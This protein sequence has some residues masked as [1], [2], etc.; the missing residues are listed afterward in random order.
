MKTL[1]Q[2]FFWTLCLVLVACSPTRTAKQGHKAFENLSYFKAIEKY[3]KAIEKGAGDDFIR[4]R[5]GDSYRLTNDMAMAEKIYMQVV[6]RDHEPE[7]QLYYGQSLMSMG[8]YDKALVHLNNFKDL[9]P[10]DDRADNLASACERI[11]EMTQNHGLY[12]IVRTNVNTEHADF[13]PS[14]YQDRVIF[15]SARTR[16]RTLFSWNRTN[17]LD[18]FEA[19]YR[20]SANLGEVNDLGSNINSRFHEAITTY[21]PDGETMYFTRNNFHKGKVGFSQE[22]VIKLKIYEAKLKGKK[23][24]KTAEFPYNS[25]EYSVGHPSLTKVGDRMYFAS[26][27]PGGQGGVDIYYTDRKGD[28][29]GKPVNLGTEINTE[30]DEMFPW[31]SPEGELYYASNG[32]PGLGGLDLFLATGK[33]GDVMSNPMNLGV[34]LN[35]S[36]DDFQLIVDEERGMGFFTSNRSG[37][38]GDDDIYAFRKNQLFEALVIDSITREPIKG[39]KAE[40]TDIRSR[41]VTAYSEGSGHFQ[42]GI[43]RNQNFLITLTKEGYEVRKQ[44]TTA[45]QVANEFPLVYEMVRVENCDPVAITLN[46]KVLEGQNLV[47]GATVKIQ[48][49]EFIVTTDENGEL[50]VPLPP[51][52]DFVVSLDEPGAINPKDIELTTKGIDKTTEIPVELAFDKKGDES[53][54]FIIYYNYDKHNIRPYDARP[55]LDRVYDYM[56]RKP[57]IKVRLS[58]HTDSRASNAYNV[59]LS[60]NRATEAFDYL[61]SRGIEQN[62]LKFEWH[63]EDDLVNGCRD[64]VKCSEEDHQLNRRTEFYLDK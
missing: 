21:T 11:L 18:L 58:S 54:F 2:I 5:L 42:S 9:R 57:A 56:A 3:Q 10:D 46:G 34:P 28:S 12:D 51:G 52:F 40:I 23:W 43:P 49:K 50:S 16:K 14:F 31:V 55:E 22:K 47:P 17:F 25:K 44:K 35:S 63:S 39:V 61:V 45:Q 48:V 4:Q 27:M 60:K 36:G 33:S 41:V 19:K 37:G 30:G 24:K 15:S 20:G 29:W 53:P 13:G 38:K 62:R 59:T 8:K 6:K 26:D 64:G 1:N 7:Y 32:L